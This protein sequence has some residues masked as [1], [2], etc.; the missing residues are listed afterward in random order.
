MRVAIAYILVALV[1]LK[2]VNPIRYYY[3]H[4][5][6]LMFYDRYTYKIKAGIDKIKLFRQAYRDFSKWGY[7]GD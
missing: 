1:F 7:W 6:F 2:I 3:Y 5:M 4:Q